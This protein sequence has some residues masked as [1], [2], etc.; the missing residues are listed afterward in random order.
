LPAGLI[1]KGDLMSLIVRSK[2]KSAVKGMR[3]SGDFY[4]ALDK[5][6]DSL[7]KAAAKRAKDN[8]RATV[9]PCDL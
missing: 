7:I 9:R 6:V 1:F 4:N 5:S 3:F 8:G 2:V